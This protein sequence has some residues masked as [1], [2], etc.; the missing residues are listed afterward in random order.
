[1]RRFIELLVFAFALP[2]CLSE[3]EERARRDLEVGKTRAAGVR[4]EVDQGLATVRSVRP[5]ELVLWGSAPAFDVELSAES[6]AVRSWTISIQNVLGDSALSALEG[7]LVSSEPDPDGI[8]TR[9][10]FRVE[11]TS[12][13]ARLRLAPP[14]TENPDTFRFAV[15]SDIQEAIDG[16]PD[17]HR[18]LNA[19]ENLRFLLGAGDL[20]QR[21]RRDELERYQDELKSLRVPYFTTLGNH[22]LGATPE[23]FHDY[24]G[25]GNFRFV[26]RGVQ[27]TLL[28]SA[29]ATLDETVYE[30]LDGWLGEGQNR[31]H[32][33]LMHIPP[34]D[35][36]GVR[37]GSFASRNEAAKLLGR[38]AR[39]NVDLTL[40]GH[41]H[42][43]YDFENAGIPAYISGGGGAVPERFDQIGRHFLVVDVDQRGVSR[44]E[45]VRVD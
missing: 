21:G 41:I 24:F 42:S 8:E 2:A 32:I 44:V 35:P 45:V 5:G 14:D 23:L 22:E 34:I 1:M 38:L 4:F 20:T 33:V 3:A 43:Y 11:L 30:W 31:V 10:R 39:G 26:F 6:D 28:D 18:K 16:L 19:V 7:A 36:I 25:R 17:I 29:S 15:L 12:D 13:R 9:R 27:F 37:N 40:Y